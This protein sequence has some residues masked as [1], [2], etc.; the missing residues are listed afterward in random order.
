MMY[1]PYAVVAGD[2]GVLRSSSSLTPH[3]AQKDLC[4]ETSFTM[5]MIVSVAD[6]IAPNDVDF[7]T[8]SLYWT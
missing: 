4:V 5:L 1:A 2:S 7:A 6:F 8:R 3:L